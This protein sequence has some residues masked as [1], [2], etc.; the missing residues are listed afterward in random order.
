M[1]ARL[2]TLAVLATAA[3]VPAAPIAEAA[4]FNCRLAGTVTEHAICNNRQLS[5]LDEQAA[6]MYFQIT[7]A[8]PPRKALEEVQAAQRAFIQQ[9]DACGAAFD[10]IVD[11]YTA[12]IMYLRNQKESLGL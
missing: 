3:I 2:V 1:L 12:Q 6:G 11:A 8:W 7:G 9:R 10:C 4:S 5:T